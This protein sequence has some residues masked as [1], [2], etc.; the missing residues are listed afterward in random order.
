[1]E[2]SAV[3]ERRAEAHSETAQ[4]Q[5]EEASAVEEELRG[6]SYTPP[7]YQEALGPLDEYRDRYQ[8]LRVQ[9]EEKVGAEGILQLKRLAEKR[10]LEE[11]R[12]LKARLAEEVNEATALGAL[13]GMDPSSDVED[14]RVE[15]NNAYA[16]A[17]G[18]YGNQTQVEQ[19]A[20]DEFEVAQKACDDLGGVP[21][22]ADGEKPA[23]P[24]QA[25]AEAK[26][27]EEAARRSEQLGNHHAGLATQAEQACAHCAS[28]WKS[29]K[30]H[31]ELLDAIT[32]S[33]Q[34][35]LSLAAINPVGS[36]PWNPPSSDDMISPR[37]RAV[38]EGLEQ[39]KQRN[40]KL[41]EGRRR[42]A[43]TIRTWASEPR[44]ELLHSDV[45]QRFATIDERDLEEQATNWREQLEL[46]IQ[47]IEA[48]LTEMNKHRDV[49]VTESLEAAEDGLSLLRSAAS[50]SRLPDYF[51]Q[52]GGAHF[53]RITTHSPES[54]SERRGR[55]AELIDELV[56]QGDI[57]VGVELVQ[58]AV[59]R[60]A[61]PIR[62]KVLN[63]DPDLAQEAVDITDM[64]LFSG[65]EQLT[66]AILL[67]CSLAQLRAR[68]RG[69]FRSPSSVL[70]LDNPIGR[71]SRV[72]FLEMQR[73]VA[74]AM[75]VQL[76]YTTAV[77]D[78]DALRTLPN[79][80]RLRNQRL[81]LNSRQRVV[82]FDVEDRASMEAARVVRR[83]HATPA[84]A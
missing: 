31:A 79:V 84:G 41:D 73:D 54:L 7:E 78:H 14:R 1:M 33:H 77:N 76:L 34:E 6:V 55:V 60:L 20:R 4:K 15:A 66:G 8:R 21:E 49:L 36:D 67:Y 53:L 11:R 5:G 80:I 2:E 47:V 74:R 16:S 12:K 38:Q 40:A 43:R 44:F 81:D 75:G 48:Q 70:I 18:T 61:K 10:A 63:P 39:A 29:L 58:A 45:V 28:G 32:R 26:S 69:R 19:R 56:D 68:T 50:Q 83:E 27:T 17:R 37:A 51:P 72:R 9:Y 42:A 46:R 59:R 52:L 82:E 64:A 24:I 65:G 13:Q 71:A 62:V 57:P 35:L 22:L 23:G 30:Q 3:A 25:D